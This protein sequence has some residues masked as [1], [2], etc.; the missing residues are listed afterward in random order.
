MGI[1]ALCKK[2]GILSVSYQIQSPLGGGLRKR[3]LSPVKLVLK[4]TLFCYCIIQ[5]C[6]FAFGEY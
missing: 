5:G 4:V 3:T 6:F 1:I 2:D